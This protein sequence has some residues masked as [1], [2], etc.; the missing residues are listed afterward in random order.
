MKKE[1]QIVLGVSFS[2]DHFVYN[3]YDRII[4]EVLSKFSQNPF[5]CTNHNL[6]S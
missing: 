2:K 1:L 5:S 6:A 3:G 4:G